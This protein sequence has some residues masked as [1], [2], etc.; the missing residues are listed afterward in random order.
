MCRF[1]S[2]LILKNGDIVHHP[3]LDS[4]AEIVAYYGMPDRT[5][6]VYH[7]AKFELVP[8]RDVL[9]VSA[10]VWRI[11]EDVM[12]QWLDDVEGQAEASARRIAQQMILTTGTRP[13][14]LDGCWIVGGD[15]RVGDMRGGRVARMVGGT[16]TAVSGGTITEVRGG[17]ITEVWGGTITEV[18]GGTIAGVVYPRSGQQS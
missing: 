15:V 13:M 17:T 12:P 8:G 9:D 11:D 3:M 5:P 1:F 16:I 10:W 4:H 18:W 14:I 2:G 6:D 7:F